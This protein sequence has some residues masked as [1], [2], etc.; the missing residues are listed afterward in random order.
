LIDPGPP[1]DPGGPPKSLKAVHV[2][3]CVMETC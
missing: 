3:L 1:P 2:E